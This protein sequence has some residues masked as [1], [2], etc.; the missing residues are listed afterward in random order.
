MSSVQV[1]SVA[2]EKR[3]ESTFH[4]RMVVSSDAEARKTLS[5]DQAMSERPFVW[6]SMLRI[7]FPVNGDHILTTLSPAVYRRGDQR[8]PH[9]NG[10]EWGLTARCKQGS[11]WAELDGGDGLRVSSE[12]VA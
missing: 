2:S 10:E 6:P 9:D 11:I 7:K 5:V 8:T 1:P 3:T 12:N 4:I